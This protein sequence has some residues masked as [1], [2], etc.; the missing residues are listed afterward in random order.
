MFKKIFVASLGWMLIA[1]SAQSPAQT[2]PVAELV[3]EFPAQSRMRLAARPIVSLMVQQGTGSAARLIPC[4]GAL[5]GGSTL[6][7]PVAYI[8]TAQH[9]V[10]SSSASRPITAIKAHMPATGA[11][12]VNIDLSVNMQPVFASDCDTSSPD[13]AD[14]ALLSVSLAPAE[15]ASLPKLPLFTRRA[16]VGERLFLFHFPDRNQIADYEPLV[17]TRANCKV[18]KVQDGYIESDCA[19]AGGSSG[20]IMFAEQ[21]GALLGIHHGKLLGGNPR[22]RATSFYNFFRSVPLMANIQYYES[23]PRLLSLVRAAQGFAPE[24]RGVMPE[25]RELVD[26]AC[27]VAHTM[28]R[29]S[30][31]KFFGE[32]L[33]INFDWDRSSLNPEAVSVLTDAVPRLEQMRS[34]L[35]PIFGGSISYVI[36][37][38]TDREGSATYNVQKSMRMADTVRSFLAVQGIP[39]GIMATVGFGESTPLVETADGVREPRNRRAEISFEA[40]IDPK[41]EIGKQCDPALE[42]Q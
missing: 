36:A 3:S 16:V 24:M 32:N 10:T 18:L 15:G 6:R 12:G 29:K 31:G 2:L 21:D 20:A 40:K 26:Q 42:S 38:H 5:V 9:C 4:T 35:A 14:V 28:T 25:Y 34:D 30:G 22:N 11:G 41:S 7:G 17:V 39:T 37:G 19:T 27:L 13:C 8:I 1:T 33:T 23:T